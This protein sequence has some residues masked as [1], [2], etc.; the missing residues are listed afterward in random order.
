MRRSADADTHQD[1]L[2]AALG[3]DAPVCPP[4]RLG[5]ES[6]AFAAAPGAVLTRPTLVGGSLYSPT[7]P[8]P[9]SPALDELARRAE[10]LGLSQILVPGVRRSEDTGPLRAAGFVPVAARSECLVRLTGDVDDVLRTRIGGRRL[11]DLRRRYHAVS[12]EVTWERIPLGELDGKPWARDAFVELHERQARRSHGHGSLYNAAALAALA[13]GGMAERTEVFVRRRGD[14]VVQAGLVTRSH[15]GQ[16]SYFLTQAID[17]DDPAARHDL[18]LAAVYRLYL[19]A[20]H[21]G[22]GWVH[23]G[24]GDVR[25][26]RGLGADLFVP[27]DHWLRAPELAAPVEEER[28]QALSAFAAPPIA[29]VPVPG[30]A[31]FRRVPRFDLI[32]LSSNTN[33][34][35]DAESHYPEL[36][37]AELARTYLRTIAKLPGHQGADALGADHLLFTSGAVDGVM[38]LL[39]ALASP[40]DG[41]CVTP[42]TFPLYEH[43]ARV[44][45]LPVTEVPLGG[46]EL[47]ELDTERILAARARVTILCD[48]GNPSGTRLDPGQVRTLLEHG[49]GLVVIDEAYVEFSEK[50]SYA[51]LVAEHDN[52]IV[53][54]TLSKAWG[55]AG[56]RCGIVLAQPGVV[57]ALR[58]VQVP[59]GFTNASQR[60]VRNRLT[61]SRAVLA[62]VEH[63]RAERDRL[64]GLL[65]EHPAVDRVFPSDTNFLLVRFRRYER[66][67]ERLRAAGILVAEVGRLVPDTC[68]ITIGTRR[69]NDALLAALFDAQ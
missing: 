6:G 68:R 41:V 12:R 60:A 67:A 40:G 50:P 19:Q 22:L 47:S 65:A 57:D 34:F 18:S 32:D 39:A 36:D 16:G 43:F 37:T 3:A 28:E 64:A 38:L 9:T 61:N 30:P 17:H 53:L 55:L 10:A 8:A 33:P 20:R 2:C 62:S 49:R 13:K 48:P 24:R 31:R 15:N 21:D 42:P 25:A 27:V 44:L 7:N 1:M 66:A 11:R 54:R 29:G 51:G 14:T 59:F 58:R 46:D 56:A 45:R 35:L 63:I 4:E 69:Q 23:L 5:P 26:K 52:L